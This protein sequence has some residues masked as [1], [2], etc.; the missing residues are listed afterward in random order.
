DQVTCQVRIALVEVGHGLDEPAVG[1]AGA[2]AGR[3]VGVLDRGAAV[4]G[5]GEAAAVV[6]PVAAGQVA[7]PPVLRADVVEHHVHDDADA[8]FAG[9]ARQRAEVLV[10]AHARV[11]PVQ[12]GD[13]VAVV[14]GGGLV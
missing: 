8:V 4:V 12:V 13:R 9:L 6:D 14:G 3:G 2:V 10:A 11:D 1:E 5:G 7:H